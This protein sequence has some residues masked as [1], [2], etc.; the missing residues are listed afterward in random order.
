MKNILPNIL[1]FY[2][3]VVSVLI[4]LSLIITNKGNTTIIFAILFLPVTAYFISELFKQLQGRENHI[5]QS[6]KGE[7]IT[8]IVIFLVLIGSGINN[9]IQKSKQNSLPNSSPLVFKTTQ[10]QS[11]TPKQSVQIDISDGSE[12]VNI[13]EK[14]TIYSEKVGE[15]KNSD[16]FTYISDKEGWFEI[17][18]TASKSGY[19]S[20]K[21]IKQ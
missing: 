16:I 6:R 18:I 1:F 9:V 3:A 11:P 13:R 4:I 17:E 14:P 7:T 2:S 19:I 12:S 20:G 21:Y 5:H 8:I 15:A 10:T